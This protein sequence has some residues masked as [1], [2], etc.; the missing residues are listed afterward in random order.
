MFHIALLEHCESAEN[1]TG[2]FHLYL[3]DPGEVDAHKAVF[4]LRRIEAQHSPGK[5]E[6]AIFPSLFTVDVIGAW[7]AVNRYIPAHFGNSSTRI[8]L[9]GQISSNVTIHTR[10]S[11]LKSKITLEGQRFKHEFVS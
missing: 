2:R 8:Q 7:P 3:H 1:E 10:D 5:T 4:T 6:G 9:Q 11:F